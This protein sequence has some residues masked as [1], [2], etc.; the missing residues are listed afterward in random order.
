MFASLDRMDIELASVEGRRQ[1]VQADH[2]DAEE[3]DAAREVP[4]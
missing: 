4:P 1:F 2:R 3:I